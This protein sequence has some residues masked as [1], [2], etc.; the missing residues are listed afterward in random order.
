MSKKKKSKHGFRMKI[1]DDRHNRK[2]LLMWHD[3]HSSGTLVL[4]PEWAIEIGAVGRMVRAQCGE[5]DQMVEEG[6]FDEEKDG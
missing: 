2:V 6:L 3:E 4:E 5:F 1:I